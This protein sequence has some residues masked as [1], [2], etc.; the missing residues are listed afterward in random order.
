MKI[1]TIKLL[2]QRECIYTDKDNQLSKKKSI[3]D[4]GA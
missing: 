4:E 2:W 3:N 1:T